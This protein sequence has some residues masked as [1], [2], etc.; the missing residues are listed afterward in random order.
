MNYSYMETER[1]DKGTQCG[2]WKVSGIGEDA[3][4]IQHVYHGITWQVWSFL[5]HS[6]ILSGPN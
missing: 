4:G 3:P 5:F 6:K 1:R 2:I